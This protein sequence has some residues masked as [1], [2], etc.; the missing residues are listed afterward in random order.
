MDDADIPKVAGV[1]RPLVPPNAVI[2]RPAQLG[3]AYYKEAGAAGEQFACSRSGDEFQSKMH[4]D[5]L[6]AV[7]QEIGMDFGS[8]QDLSPLEKRKLVALSQAS[9]IEGLPYVG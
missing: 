5:D 4:H 1:L 3:V 7:M 6:V 8:H 9:V 2:Q